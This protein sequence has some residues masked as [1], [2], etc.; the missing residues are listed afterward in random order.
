MKPQRKQLTMGNQS[1]EVKSQYTGREGIP[2]KTTFS[3]GIQP[4]V[5]K[6]HHT[7]GP[8]K[9]KK[10]KPVSKCFPL[11]AVNMSGINVDAKFWYVNIKTWRWPCIKLFDS[12]HCF[13]FVFHNSFF[14]YFH[15][16]YSE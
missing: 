2:M 9:V 12:K 7:Q 11:R 6:D 16:K 5:Y 4:P 10:C 3:S 8:L 14:N 13:V 1:S 15:T